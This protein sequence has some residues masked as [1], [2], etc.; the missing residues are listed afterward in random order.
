MNWEQTIAFARE[1]EE[2]KDLINACYLSPDLVLNVKNYGA[3]EEFKEILKLIN[4]YAPSAKNLIE[5]GAGNGIASINFSLAGY[6]VL[7]TEPDKS[8]TVGVGAIKKLITHFDLK[9]ISVVE[10]YA[11]EIKETDNK[12]DIVFARQCMHH[13]NDLMAFTQNA[14]RL[15]KPGGL[16]FTVLDH[17]INSE[18]NKQEFFKS[19]PF[20]KYYGGENAF[21]LEEYEQALLSAGFRINK[22]LNYFDSVINYFPEKDPLARLAHQRND[23]IS[24]KF[25]ILS[26]SAITKGILLK[27]FEF[28]HGQINDDS[29]II[30]RMYSF[31]ATK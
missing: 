17:V 22:R 31:L 19:H 15:L 5:F 6:S 23:Q 28:K 8:E 11:E 1:Q 10:S 29:N 25:P 13:A 3:S 27:L 7:S 26:N 21:T 9:N 24:N 16:F 14:Y 2:Y 20:H 30:G 18:E 12:F 4:E